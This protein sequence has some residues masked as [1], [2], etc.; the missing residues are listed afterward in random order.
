MA[1]PATEAIG[2]Y[3]ALQR[4]RLVDHQRRGGQQLCLL[5]FLLACIAPGMAFDACG[6]CIARHVLLF[7]FAQAFCFVNCRWGVIPSAN[8]TQQ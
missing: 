8:H 1:I 6:T 5:V 3:G 7:G 2:C 4:Q